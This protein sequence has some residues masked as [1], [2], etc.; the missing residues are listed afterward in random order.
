MSI[1]LEWLDEQKQ[2]L[3]YRIKSPLTGAEIHDALKEARTLSE[4]SAFTITI[5]D[6]TECNNVPMNILSSIST[7]KEYTVDSVKLRII[8]GGSMLVTRFFDIIVTLIP[9]MG[10]T[11]Q[12]V[13]TMDE[14]IALLEGKKVEI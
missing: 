8:V 6:L 5:F 14:A 2:T 7:M 9:N 3:V 10:K 11:V 13:G 12:S 4:D 1:K